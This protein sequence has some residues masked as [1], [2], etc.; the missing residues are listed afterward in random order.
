[1]LPAVR[2][3]NSSG[4]RP[5]PLP[6]PARSRRRAALEKLGEYLDFR[7]LDWQPVAADIAALEDQ[8]RQLEASSD[9]L[10]DL[11]Q[12]MQVVESELDQSERLLTEEP[13]KRA[14]TEQRPAGALRLAGHSSPGPNFPSI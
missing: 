11:T 13:G 9:I 1:M 2:P 8:R 6:A 5:A 10:R 7:E 14:K 12:R 4:T 3:R